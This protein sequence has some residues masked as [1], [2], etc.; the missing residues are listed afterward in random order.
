MQLNHTIFLIVIACMFGGCSKRKTRII[1]GTLLLCKTI[2][3]PIANRQIEIYQDGSGYN[4]PIYAGSESSS[5]TGKTDAAGNFEIRFKPGKAEFLIFS[6]AN[7]SPLTL[8]PPYGDT[9]FP[10]FSRKNFN[11]SLYGAKPIYIGKLIDTLI[12]HLKLFQDLLP[13]DTIAANVYNLDRTPTRLY[14]GF[15]APSGSE[16]IVDTFYQA[17]ATGYDEELGKFYTPVSFGKRMW[18]PANYV[19]TLYRYPAIE[20][21]SP[22]DEKRVDVLYNWYY[23]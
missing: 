3:L 19:T 20:Y 18:V 9:S 10:S 2:P 22:D 7:A 1:K 16:I 14:W 5:A 13:T 4:A 6:G 12:I 17:L 8:R 23:Q 21:L 15:S 11:D